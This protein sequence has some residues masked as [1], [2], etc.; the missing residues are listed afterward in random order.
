V[1]VP[2]ALGA[3]VCVPLMDWLPVNSPPLALEV[4]ALHEEAE[5]EVHTK[6]KA[7]PKLID[8]AIA[9]CV[10]PAVGFCEGAGAP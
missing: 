3:T 8:K 9:G 1:Y 4:A 7:W 5:A 6:V 2:G 10:K